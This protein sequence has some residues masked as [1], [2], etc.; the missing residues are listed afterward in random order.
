[1]LIIVPSLCCVDQAQPHL[2]H[3]G[4]QRGSNLS[5]GHAFFRRDVQGVRTHKLHVCLDGHAEISRT[6]HFRDRLRNEP[7]LRD[8]YQH[9]KL[10][11][12]RTNTAGIGEYIA[13]KSPF[14][15]AALT[16]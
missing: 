4:Y 13:G 15:T 12:A 11:L 5:A 7:T 9:L 8:A 3:L 14:I 16:G 1:M 6:L 10:T 2:Q